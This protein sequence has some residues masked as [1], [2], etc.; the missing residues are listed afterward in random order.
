MFS[1]CIA[2]D[3]GSC[4]QRL[5]S[6]NSRLFQRWFNPHPRHQW[7]F[8]RSPESSTQEN[9]QELTDGDLNSIPLQEA[10]VPH[11][12]T[13]VQHR[14][15]KKPS[16]LNRK[17]T[18]KL[19]AAAASSL[20]M[21]L[22]SAPPML[23][24]LVTLS[25]FGPWELDFSSPTCVPRLCTLTIKKL[26]VFEELEN[27]LISVAIAVKMQGSKSIPMSQEIVLPPVDKWRQTWS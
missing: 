25:Q 10:Q 3:W 19:Q 20:P 6:E 27:E 4:F 2:S 22:A 8:S 12:S 14:L 13:R 21:G 15:G 16:A 1:C 17:R 11:T 23:N 5:C 9:G 26:V 18:Y 7:P 24:M